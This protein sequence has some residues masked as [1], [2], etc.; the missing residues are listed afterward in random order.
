MDTAHSTDQQSSVALTHSLWAYELVFHVESR[1]W[2]ICWDDWHL[3]EC[4]AEVRTV[5]AW[6]DEQYGTPHVGSCVCVCVKKAEVGGCQSAGAVKTKRVVFLGAGVR[7]VWTRGLPNVSTSNFVFREIPIDGSFVI[8]IAAPGFTA[9]RL[10]L[11]GPTY[12]QPFPV[13]L[14]KSNPLIL[15]VIPRG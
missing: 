1:P 10:T 11:N 8:T 3:V 6:V 7:S 13:S 2:V 15:I 4:S 12:D 9:T 14:K 5:R